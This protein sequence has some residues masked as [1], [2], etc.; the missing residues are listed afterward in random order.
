MCRRGDTSSR[1]S[2]DDHHR[3][4]AVAVA[5]AVGVAVGV[6][7]VVGVAVA[8]VVVVVVVVAV[9]VAVVVVV[10]VVVGVVVWV[11]VGVTSP[12]YDIS[13]IKSRRAWACGSRG[14]ARRVGTTSP[15]AAKCWFNSN[16]V[17][18]SAQP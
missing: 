10:V 3:R 4:V 18:D 14:R 2:S 7:V 8:V 9:G 5:V 16:R 17:H 1:G 13:T 15:D 6:V 12:A 11:A